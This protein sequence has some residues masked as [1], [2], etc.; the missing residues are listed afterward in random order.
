MAGAA[1][2]SPGG[3]NDVIN[4]SETDTAA[5]L[6]F[7]AQLADPLGVLRD[8][9][10]AATPFCH[11]V[12]VSCSAAAGGCVSPLSGCKTCLSKDVSP[13]ALELSCICK[14]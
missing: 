10:T 2:P 13:L 6:T 3:S 5:L 8:N 1:A 7:K 4:G 12:G 11:W 14:L 9:W